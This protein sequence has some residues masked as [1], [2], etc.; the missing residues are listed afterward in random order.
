[1]LTAVCSEL[2]SDVGS[3]MATH[4]GYK[5]ATYLSHVNSREG[6]PFNPFLL[7]HGDL[8]IRILIHLTSA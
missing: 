8:F 7:W 1:M 4:S 3:E 5:P 6:L 2:V